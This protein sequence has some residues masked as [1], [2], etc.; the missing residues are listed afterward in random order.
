MAIKVIEERLAKAMRTLRVPI[1]SAAV[2]L[3]LVQISLVKNG[4]I[5]I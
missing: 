1:F 5:G 3:I 4:T 2:I